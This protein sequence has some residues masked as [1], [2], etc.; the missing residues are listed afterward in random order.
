MPSRDAVDDLDD[1]LGF[2]ELGQRAR[3]SQP[4]KAAVLHP[5]LL[6]AVR[7]RRPAVDPDRVGLQAR[8]HAL[9]AIDVALP[10]ELWNTCRDGS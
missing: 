5:A 6:V 4:A 2:L 1:G 8:D 3:A 10:Y 7:E 9:R